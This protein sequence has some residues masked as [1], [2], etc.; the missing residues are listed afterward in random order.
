MYQFYTYDN[1]YFILIIKLWP[2][3]LNWMCDN[4]LQDASVTVLVSF[5][6]CNRSDERPARANSSDSHFPLDIRRNER[7]SIL[8]YINFV[9]Y[10]YYYQQWREQI[11][12][13]DNN[14]N[15]ESLS[16]CLLSNSFLRYCCGL[17]SIMFGMVALFSALSWSWNMTAITPK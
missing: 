3:P 4:M 12:D 9:Y 11:T 14:F 15:E 1:Q 6:L 2:T 10:C 17:T 5:D 13:Y 8:C 7:N 16:Q